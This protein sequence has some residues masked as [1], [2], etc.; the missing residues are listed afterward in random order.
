[1]LNDLKDQHDA[2]VKLINVEDSLKSSRA[3]KKINIMKQDNISLKR[4]ITELTQTKEVLAEKVKSLVAVK[5]SI[6]K[7]KTETNQHIIAIQA[8]VQECEVEKVQLEG[9]LKHQLF[10]IHE[11]LTVKQA[12][13]HTCSVISS[14]IKAR[15]LKNENFSS[16]SKQPKHKIKQNILEVRKNLQHKLLENYKYSTA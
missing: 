10:I 12:L 6:N 3:E 8:E 14:E 4:N 1:M 7:E 13:L 15:T 2:L 11:A 5:D 16:K 9:L